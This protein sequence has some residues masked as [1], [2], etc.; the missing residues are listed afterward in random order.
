[1]SSEEELATRRQT[2]PSGSRTAGSK[3]HDKAVEHGNAFLQRCASDVELSRAQAQKD[4]HHRH[5]NSSRRGNYDQG[6]SVDRLIEEQR[7]DDVANEMAFMKQDMSKILGLVGRQANEIAVLRRRCADNERAERHI[8]RFRDDFILLRSDFD[9]HRARLINSLNRH[10]LEA[11]GAELIPPKKRRGHPEERPVERFKKVPRRETPVLSPN[12]R[13]ETSKRQFFGQNHPARRISPKRPR[14][15]SRRPSLRADSLN[16]N[17]PPTNTERVKIE[18]GSP[19]LRQSGIAEYYGQDW[20]EHS[21]H[22]A[23]L[24]SMGDPRLDL[25]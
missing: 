11:V 1:M 24:D 21:S 8:D 16:E 25:P 20:P 10:Q 17:S 7:L 2:S 12:P 22:Q 19:S 5:S 14:G 18:S 3:S 15:L 23:F 9:S 4:S 13:A 6:R